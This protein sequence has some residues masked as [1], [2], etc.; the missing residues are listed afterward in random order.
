MFGDHWVE[1]NAKTS[2][3]PDYLKNIH[4]QKGPKS[5]GYDNG[6]HD[7]DANGQPKTV[8][9]T[10]KGGIPGSHPKN[11]PKGDDHIDSHADHK[12]T[13][14]DP[15]KLG[16][17]AYDRETREI[18]RMNRKKKSDD[19]KFHERFMRLWKDYTN[20]TG[21][22]EEEKQRRLNIM[23]SEKKLAMSKLK[24]ASPK[25]EAKKARKLVKKAQKPKIP[26]DRNSLVLGK[27]SISEETLEKLDLQTKHFEKIS[28]QHGEPLLNHHEKVFFG[29]KKNRIQSAPKIPTKNNSRITKRW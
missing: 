21:I 11:F 16:S 26:K 10:H 29:C 19:E 13:I 15:S 6:M 18:S 25:R 14:Y 8:H 5:K 24:E 2:G 3:D 4:L 22:S 9:E 7:F 20:E 28:L 17:M 12:G 27:I 1:M 23:E